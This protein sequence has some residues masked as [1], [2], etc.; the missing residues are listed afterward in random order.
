M[1]W[2]RQNFKNNFVSNFSTKFQF[3][4]KKNFAANF[5]QN[6]ILWV[7]YTSSLAVRFCDQWGYL[8][9]RTGILFGAQMRF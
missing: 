4:D 9:K 3:S 5:E 8:P 1:S 7:I 2:R 6:F